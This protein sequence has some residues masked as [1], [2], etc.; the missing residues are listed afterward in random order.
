MSAEFYIRYL[1]YT[2]IIIGGSILSSRLLKGKIKSGVALAA[3]SV[4]IGDI[5]EIVFSNVLSVVNGNSFSFNIYDIP[6]FGKLWNLIHFVPGLAGY[7]EYGL[8]KYVLPI[9]AVDVLLVAALIGSFIYILKT[10]PT[11]SDNAAVKTSTPN[12]VQKKK[13]AANS[14]SIEEL[15]KYKELLDMNAIT[16]E[17]Y[18]AK[19]KEILGL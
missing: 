15:K 5:A 17:E 8:L 13:P 11:V 4:A 2:A 19:K 18:N 10:N 14:A 6:I 3:I 16:Q 1:I 12:T 7:I 9:I